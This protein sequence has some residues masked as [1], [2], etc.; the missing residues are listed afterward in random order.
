MTKLQVSDAFQQAWQGCLNPMWFKVLSV[1]RDN[2]SLRVECHSFTGY[3]HEEEWHSSLLDA[4][5]E[6]VYWINKSDD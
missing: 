4:A 2:N 3:V 5:F 1:D 6:L